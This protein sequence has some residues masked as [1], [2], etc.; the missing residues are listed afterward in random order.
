MNNIVLILKCKL[1][2]LEMLPAQETNQ[3]SQACKLHTLPLELWLALALNG[4]YSDT[5][6]KRLIFKIDEVTVVNTNRY[7]MMHA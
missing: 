7:V 5:M 3:G 4:I 6:L 2:V 1:K